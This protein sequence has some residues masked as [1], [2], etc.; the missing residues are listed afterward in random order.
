M[1]AYAWLFSVAYL[2][3]GAGVGALILFGAVQVSMF[4]WG[5]L[6]RE[7]L[8]RRVLAG[9]LLA[10]T[11]LVAQLLPGAGAPALGSALLMV[12]SGVAWGGLFVAGQGVG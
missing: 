8:N 5:L 10:F 12:L 11:G 6:R 1:L 3:L 7:A 2:Q 9:M 4:A